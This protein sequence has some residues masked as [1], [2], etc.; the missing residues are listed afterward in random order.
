MG[1][2]RNRWRDGLAGG[3]FAA[4]GLRRLGWHRRSRVCGPRCLSHL[5]D[6]CHAGAAMGTVHRTIGTMSAAKAGS[7][8]LQGRG[9]QGYRPL[10]LRRVW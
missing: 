8:R 7:H 2:L 3:Y 4:R 9:E 5:C 10:S 6:L 1:F